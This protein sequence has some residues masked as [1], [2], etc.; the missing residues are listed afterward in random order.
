[1]TPYVSADAFARETLRQLIRHLERKVA[2]TPCLCDR[3]EQGD[4]PRHGDDSP[5]EQ[6]AEA[7]YDLGQLLAQDGAA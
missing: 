6:L 4:C 7:R 3:I 5:G 2:E 1:M